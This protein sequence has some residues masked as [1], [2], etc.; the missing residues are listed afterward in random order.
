MLTQV[1][2]SAAACAGRVDVPASKFLFT[3]PPDLPGPVYRHSTPA[4]AL[5]R[6]R[7]SDIKSIRNVHV[8]RGLDRN[9]GETGHPLGSLTNYSTYCQDEKQKSLISKAEDVRISMCFCRGCLAFSEHVSR[10]SNPC[11]LRKI[12]KLQK[13]TMYLARTFCLWAS[14]FPWRAET[15]LFR[16]YQPDDVACAYLSD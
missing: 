8:R 11:C 7:C 6:H 13:S 3:S 16:C 12:R 5:K 14:Q 1:L 2:A 10:G 4:S 15:V 9:P